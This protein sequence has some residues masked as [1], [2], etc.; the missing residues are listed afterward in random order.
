MDFF[1]LFQVHC[2]SNCVFKFLLLICIL[3]DE[4]NLCINNLKILYFS[5][6]ARDTCPT[7]LIP[8]VLYSCCWFSNT[9]FLHKLRQ[10]QHNLY[11]R[12][13]FI[14]TVQLLHPYTMKNQITELRKQLNKQA[15]G[16]CCHPI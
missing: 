8:E 1:R 13:K 16:E 9:C 12:R 14:W 5:M 3:D 6:Y 7:P 2:D 10:Q 11:Q 15:T 4:Q